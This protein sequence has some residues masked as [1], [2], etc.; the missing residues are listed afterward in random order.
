MSTEREP[1][2]KRVKSTGVA[3]VGAVV[4][5]NPDAAVPIPPL[6]D[7]ASLL[8]LG[9]KTHRFINCELHDCFLQKE[10]ESDPGLGSLI[11]LI[12]TA[13]RVQDPIDSSPSRS[14]A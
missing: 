8:T 12:S 6:C 9:D 2:A 14:M 13:D 11:Q 5:E 7:Y 4:Y 10:M 1:T 3:W